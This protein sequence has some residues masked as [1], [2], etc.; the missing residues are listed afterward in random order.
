MNTD[1]FLQALNKRLTSHSEMQIANESQFFNVSA[2]T[3][4][5]IILAWV[6][7]QLSTCNTFSVCTKEGIWDVR[8]NAGKVEVIQREETLYDRYIL[9]FTL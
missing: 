8:N 7:N 6:H 1:Q 4:Q 9:G 5:L 2:Y 3:D